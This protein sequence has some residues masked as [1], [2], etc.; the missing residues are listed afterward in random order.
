MSEV[1]KWGKWHLSSRKMWLYVERWSEHDV[2]QHHAW[3]IGCRKSPTGTLCPAPGPCVGKWCSSTEAKD[4]S[5]TSGFQRLS[6]LL[7][8][9]G[10]TLIRPLASF[11]TVFMKSIT[12]QLNAYF[13]VLKCRNH[14]QA[15]CLSKENKTSC[16][17]KVSC[18]SQEN[19][20]GFMCSGGQTYKS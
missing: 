20:M 11:H 14:D 1:R 3:L 18:V 19:Q 2:T 7:G 5:D 10:A 16:M 17:S 9:L 8:L 13:Y 6:T 15:S 12:R 4:L